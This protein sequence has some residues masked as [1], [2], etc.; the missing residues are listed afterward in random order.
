MRGNIFNL[1]GQKVLATNVSRVP[2]PMYQD[3]R[4]EQTGWGNML[5]SADDHQSGKHVTRNTALEKGSN[6]GWAIKMDR[7]RKISPKV[8]GP[9]NTWMCL[10]CIE[11]E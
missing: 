3:D 2:I 4:D 6:Q 5:Q 1:S 11:K 8:L 7:T 10:P 9:I